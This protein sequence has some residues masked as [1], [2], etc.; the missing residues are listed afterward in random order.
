MSDDTNWPTPFQDYEAAIEELECVS[1]ALKAARADRGPLHKYQRLID[2][3]AVARERVVR[4]RT[5]LITI[6]ATDPKINLRSQLALP[7]VPP[8]WSEQS[9]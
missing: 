6:R 9:S 4:I 5:R 3:E 8:E 2:A 7:F 1:R